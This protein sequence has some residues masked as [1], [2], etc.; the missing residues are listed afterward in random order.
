[1]LILSYFWAGWRVP[2]LGPGP[3]PLSPPWSWLCC[4]VLGGSAVTPILSLATQDVSDRIEKEPAA[5]PIVSALE[6]GGRAVVRTNWRMHISL[7]LQT[8]EPGPVTG[9]DPSARA[10]GPKIGVGEHASLS[11]GGQSPGLLQAATLA[12]LCWG[13]GSTGSHVRLALAM[14]PLAQHLSHSLQT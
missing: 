10:Q 14:S 3:N 1:M 13:G 11:L 5:G 6:A 4:P 12:V 2:G 8:G 9:Q 7:P